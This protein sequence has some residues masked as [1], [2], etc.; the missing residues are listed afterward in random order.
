[1]PEKY[2]GLVSPETRRFKLEVPRPPLPTE[3]VIGQDI[4]NRIPSVIDLS[5]YTQFVIVTEEGLEAQFEFGSKVKEGLQKTGKPVHI[6]TS[7]GSERK[8]TEEE[9]DK[10]LAGVLRIEPQIDRKLLMLAVGGGVMGDVVGY[11][12]SRALRGVDYFQVPTTLL[13]MVDSS[14]GGKTGVDFDDIKNRVGSFHL[15]RATI[16]DIDVLKKLPK[17]QITSGF[18]EFVKHAFLDENI[19][20]FILGESDRSIIGDRDKLIKGLELSAKYKLGIVS[21][22]YEEKTGVRQ[23]LNLGHT[24]GHAL[25]TGAGLEK[26]THGEAVAIGLTGAISMSYRLGLL[27]AENTRGMIDVIIR[28]GLPRSTKGI[29]DIDR[30]LLWKIM[31]SD[32]KAVNGVPKFTLLEGIGRPKVG[33]LV[34]KKIVDEVLDLISL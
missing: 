5:G 34:D 3:V 8:K 22:D 17:R 16:E 9:A 27:S 13:A 18:A 28:F 19:F 23:V 12:A 32:K 1:M 20:K 2:K 15:S 21:Q 7:E 31:A 24:F 29:V 25:E 6:F 14:I 10:I 30:N 26:L 33:C 4:L 11:V